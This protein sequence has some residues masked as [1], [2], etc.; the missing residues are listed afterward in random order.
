[1]KILGDSGSG[2]SNWGTQAVS[3]VID[4]WE[5][6]LKDM[7]VGCG[8][9]L[10]VGGPHD[11]G[12]QRACDA[13]EKAGI[14]LCAAAGNSGGN[15]GVDSPGDYRS[16]LGTASY[17]IDGL[18]SEFSSGG[19]EVDFAMPGERIMSTW[20]DNTYRAISG[21]SMATPALAGLCACSISSRPNDGWVKDTKG[22][23]K[24]LAEH[25]ED[26]GQPGPDKR[27]GLGVPN[28]EHTVRNPEWWMF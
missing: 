19:P 12:Q 1:M 26:R 7:Y 11:N 8:I 21:T 24:L 27:F 16:T 9:S 20:L 2:S 28:A 10:S 15:A 5:T 23:R 22:Q 4:L 3:K 18:I 6:V 25:A 14:Y 13:A 17:R